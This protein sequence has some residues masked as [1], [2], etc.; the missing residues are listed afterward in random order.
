MTFFANCAVPVEIIVNVASGVNGANGECCVSEGEVGVLL[1]DSDLSN[2][3][4]KTQKGGD[5]KFHRTRVL[6]T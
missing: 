1:G 6:F 4:R 5:A 2:E 3:K